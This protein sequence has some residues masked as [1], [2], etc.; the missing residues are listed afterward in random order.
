MSRE[1]AKMILDVITRHGA[2]QDAALAKIECL[3]TQ[4]EFSQ[5][6]QMIGRSMGTMLLDVIAPIVKKYPDLKPPQLT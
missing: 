6:K 4:E 5:F 2:E 1:A 3:C